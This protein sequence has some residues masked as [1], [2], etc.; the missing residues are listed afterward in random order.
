MED[1]SFINFLHQSGVR[2]EH[3]D[4]IEVS[5][6]LYCKFHP[7][8]KFPGE[9]LLIL[10][11]SKPGGSK[12]DRRASRMYGRDRGIKVSLSGFLFERLDGQG[13]VILD[14]IRLLHLSLLRK[15]IKVS[16]RANDRI[17]ALD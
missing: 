12:S 6:I 10:E 4:W 3:L 17:S 13:R 7:S 5:D 2:V 15:G 16:A 1:F 11:C 8:S 14:P 9:V